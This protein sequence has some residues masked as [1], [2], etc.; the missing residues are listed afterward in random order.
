MSNYRVTVPVSTTPPCQDTTQLADEILQR[1]NKEINQAVAEAFSFF[2]TE[3]DRLQGKNNELRQRM[4]GIEKE[5]EL[6]IDDLEQYGR[7]TCLRFFGIPETKGESTDQI[8][9]RVCKEKVNVELK[10][11]DIPRSHRVGPI[12]QPGQD[13]GR[14]AGKERHRP[15]IVRFDGYRTRQRVFAAKRMLK[16]TGI[17]VRED[18]KHRL[19]ILNAAANKY[20]IRNTWTVDGRIKY[21]VGEGPGRRIY[22]AERLADLQ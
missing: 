5:T 11:D 14:A 19:A 1:I 7:R 12:Q 18:L 22:T 9:L 20:G 13:T 6:K 10:I 15:I 21:A 16:N 2:Q 17:T 3:L 8:V 4:P